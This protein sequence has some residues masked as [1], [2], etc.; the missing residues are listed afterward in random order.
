[1][2]DDNV[3]SLVGERGRRQWGEIE[4][5]VDY[6]QSSLRIDYYQMAGLNRWGPFSVIV[7]R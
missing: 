2:Y 5:G 4:L 1:M 7:Y 3:L 6:G